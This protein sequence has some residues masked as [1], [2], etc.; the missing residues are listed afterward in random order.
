[1]KNELFKNVKY[2]LR[3]LFGGLDNIEKTMWV[4]VAVLTTAVCITVTLKYIIIW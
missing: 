2:D 4:L 1:M 3:E